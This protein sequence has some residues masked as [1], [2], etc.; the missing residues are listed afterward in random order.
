MGYAIFSKLLSRNDLSVDVEIILLR[1]VHCVVAVQTS[2]HIQADIL[3][4]DCPHQPYRKLRE[5]EI[6]RY[7]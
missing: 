1:N 6:I 3:I 4:S 7:G 5:H 2:V